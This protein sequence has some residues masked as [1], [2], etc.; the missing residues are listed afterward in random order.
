MPLEE[1]DSEGD[2]IVNSRPNSISAEIFKE[3]AKR[4]HEDLIKSS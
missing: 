4:L 2:P 3:L 1:S